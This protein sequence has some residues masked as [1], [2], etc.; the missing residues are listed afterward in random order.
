MNKFF[1]TSERNIQILIY[2]LKQHKIR[3]VVA[4]PGATNVTF[5]A[6]LQHD[7]YFEIYSSYDERSAAYLACGLARESGEAV[8]LS[9]TGATAS[10]NYMPGLTEAYYRKLPVLAVTSTQDISR[11][12]HYIPQV[13]DRSKQPN[14]I[15]LLSEHIQTVKDKTDEWD[16]TIKV[17]R[18]LLELHH[19]GGGPVHI[20][21][22]TTYSRDYSVKELSPARIIR[23]VT[24]TDEY[25]SL[26]NCKIGIFI[27]AHKKFTEEETAVIDEFCAANN[28][29]VFCDHTS[30]FFGKYRVLYSLARVQRQNAPVHTNPDIL[31]HIGE[32]SGD[33]TNPGKA[34][35]EIWRV[36]D[37]GEIRDT[38]N[39]LTYVFEMPEIVFFKHYIPLEY[40]P[41]ETYFSACKKQL[42]EVRKQIP[43][44]P[45]SN[46][47]VAQQ[48]AHR[49]PKNSVVHLSI[50]NT[51]RSWNYFEF[52]ESVQ[53]SCNTGGFGI[54]GIL[55]T[56]VGAS[57][58]DQSKL[59]FAVIGDLAFFYDMNVIANRHVGKNLRVLLVNNGKGVEFKN[60]D[61][62]AAVFGDET[63]VYIAAAGHNG[64]KS[65]LLVKHYAEDLGFDYLSATTKEEFCQVIDKFVNPNYME[66]SILLEVFTNDVEESNA[67]KMIRYCSTSPAG[68]SKRIIKHVLGKNA[69]AA[70]KKIIGH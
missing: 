58:V 51:L 4:S 5:V 40:T 65:K 27:G 26:P 14:D 8:V 50:L 3:K 20:N 16:V 12:G 59:Y 30:S 11:V 49:I 19:R 22:S 63:D 34:A 6:S 54:D 47:W 7:P 45:F 61:H 68:V 57:L 56:L 52:Q 60:Y 18:A 62:K 17:N 38:F 33:Y 9:C 55:S 10:R 67:L 44:L 70:I 66:K 35:K 15:V 31:I 43:E 32:V 64:N 13:I 23:R 29:V 41:K 1:Y 37:D 46:I 39:R 28:A 2:L 25:P 24:Q 53:S 21:L 48:T 42:E 69:T 36:S